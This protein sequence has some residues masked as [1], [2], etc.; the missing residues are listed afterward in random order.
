MFLLVYRSIDSHWQPKQT[1]DTATT[2]S[3][4]LVIFKNLAYRIYVPNAHFK[5]MKAI[6]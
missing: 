1:Y 5:Y 3:T 4:I 2:T 6:Q